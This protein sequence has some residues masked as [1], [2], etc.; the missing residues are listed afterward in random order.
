MM[1]NLP[2]HKSIESGIMAISKGKYFDRVHG[3]DV[4]TAKAVI[5][6]KGQNYFINKFEELRSAC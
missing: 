4:Q 1:Y 3:Y 6:A 5:T 2:A